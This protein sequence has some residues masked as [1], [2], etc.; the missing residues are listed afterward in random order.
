MRSTMALANMG[1][2][3]TLSKPRNPLR[4]VG[5]LAMLLGPVLAMTGL[6]AM[7][8]AAEPAKQAPAETAP[9]PADSARTLPVGNPGTTASN[10]GAEARTY[11]AREAQAKSLEQFKGGD[12]VVIAG[13]TVVLVLLVVLLIVLI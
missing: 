4:L 3:G 13:S 1:K 11:E 12:T 5:A 8:T 9:P 2:N 10:P 6:P 7:A